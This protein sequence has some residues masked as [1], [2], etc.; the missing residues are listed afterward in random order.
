MRRLLS[1][2]CVIC[3]TPLPALEL[4]LSGFYE[5]NRPASLDY[6]P[7]FCGLWIANEGPEIILV[8]LDGLELRRFGSDLSRIKAVTLE[9]TT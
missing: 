1:F 4:T 7:A 5:L 2:L 8:T 3:A 9:G 6:D